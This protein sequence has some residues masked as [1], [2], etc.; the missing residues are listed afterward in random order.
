MSNAQIYA[1][2]LVSENKNVKSQTLKARLGV[3]PGTGKPE[4]ISADDD[5]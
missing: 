5:Q 2:G 3:I 4:D 1:P